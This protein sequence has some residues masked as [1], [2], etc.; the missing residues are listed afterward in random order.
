MA[1]TAHVEVWRFDSINLVKITGVLD[2]A[3]SV[4][5]RLVLFEQLDAGADQVVVDLAGV[6]LID[7]SAVGVML[8]VQEQLSERG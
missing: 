7:A 4:R 8:R 5:L 1:E 6:R 3:A 2:F